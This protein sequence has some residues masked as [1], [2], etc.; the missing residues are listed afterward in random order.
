ME[1]ADSLESVVCGFASILGRPGKP[2]ELA[3]VF[4]F[5][6]S[7][8]SSYVNAQAINVDGGW[9]RGFTHA[10]VKKLLS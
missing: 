7:D 8:D 6:A 9:V 4:H 1:P 10:T 5:L 2:E 3:A